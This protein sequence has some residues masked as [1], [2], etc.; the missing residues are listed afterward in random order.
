MTTSTSWYTSITIVPYY[1][2]ITIFRSTETLLVGSWITT[3]GIHCLLIPVQVELL[4]FLICMLLV[5]Q[6]VF[7]RGSIVSNNMYITMLNDLSR[8]SDLARTSYST[9]SPPMVGF[10]FLEVSTSDK[11]G[12]IHL[13]YFIEPKIDQ[14]WDLKRCTGK[15]ASL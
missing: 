13:F 12:H 9:P 7:N 4:P 14:F 11:E 1:V 3:E 10:R 8:V 5:N 2:V 6:C 15:L